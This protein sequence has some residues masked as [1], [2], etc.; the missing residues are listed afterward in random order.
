MPDDTDATY[1]IKE[2][3]ALHA[4]HQ[5]ELRKTDLEHAQELR[6][7]DQEAIAVAL[8]TV[9]EQRTEDRETDRAYR[10]TQ[11]N[12]RGESSDRAAKYATRSEVDLMF[13]NQ[14][15]D[16]FSGGTA[17]RSTAALVVS[18]V[19]AIVVLYQTFVA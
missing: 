9:K 16:K 12:W 11:N 19:L 7:A 4:L 5:A 18:L 6:R 3:I 15:G 14:K 1:S 13:Q 8:R 2:V 17:W 10:E